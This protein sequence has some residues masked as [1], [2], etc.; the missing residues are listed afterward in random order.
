MQTTIV[1]TPI[2]LLPLNKQI[3]SH[4]LRIKRIFHSPLLALPVP[5]LSVELPDSSG[6][7]HA[8]NSRLDQSRAFVSNKMQ[9]HLYCVNKLRLPFK[10]F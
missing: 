1:N 4:V 3:L 10:H 9:R 2:S 5:L 8:A 7:I 6:H